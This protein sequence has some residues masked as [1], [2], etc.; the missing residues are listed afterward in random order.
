MSAHGQTYP[1]PGTTALRTGRAAPLNDIFSIWAER[2]FHYTWP[3]PQISFR[4]ITF[5]RMQAT[6]LI[7]WYS[8]C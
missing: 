7:L 4:D 6:Y 3:T 2:M 5:S 8:L 1:I